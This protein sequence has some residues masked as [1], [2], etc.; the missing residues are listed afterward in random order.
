MHVI[1]PSEFTRQSLVE[2]YDV[3]ADKISLLPVGLSDRF[4]RAQAGE[5]DSMRLRYDLPD[6]FIF[7]PANPWQHKNHARLMAALRIYQDRYNEAPYLV[8]S[9]RLPNERRDFISLAIAS[10]IEDR[11]TDLGFVSSE[12]IRALY[13]AATM[14]VFPSLFEGFGIPLIEAMAS[15]CPIAGANATTVP[16]ITNGAALLFDPLIL[17]LFL[18]QYTV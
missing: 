1:A 17:K 4:R 2:K 7:Y 3:P 6:D 10:G 11:V 12:D 13:S 9:G 18:M 16:E 14:M 8:L 5:T 15:G